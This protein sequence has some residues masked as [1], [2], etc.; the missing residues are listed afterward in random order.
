MR[1]EAIPIIF[2]FDMSISIL[3]NNKTSIHPIS[4][5]HIIAIPTG[6]YKHVK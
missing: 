1:H 6:S 5:T 3:T 2:C 4:I